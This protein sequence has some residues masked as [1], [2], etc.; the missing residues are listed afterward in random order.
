MCPTAFCLTSPAVA[1]AIAL[2]LLTL[3][4][5]A[6]PQP[7]ARN[8]TLVAAPAA[9][10]QARRVALVIG[11][12]RYASAPLLNPV[13]DARAMAKALEA[14]G[15]QVMLR[16]DANQ[17]DLLTAV[18]EFGHRLRDSQVGVFYFAGHGMQIKG[19]NYLIPVG[20]DIE[21]ED[22]IAYQ[23]LDA[24]AVLDKMESAGNSTNLMIL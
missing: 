4:L 3:A 17:R 22:E 14:A 2:T 11:N 10:T 7:P 13:N 23:A 20:A 16:I 21:R 15:F 24:Q 6:L 18:R 1:T 9:I 5:P 12:N 8:L 19:R